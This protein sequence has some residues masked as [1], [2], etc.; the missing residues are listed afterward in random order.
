MLKHEKEAPHFNETM[1]VLHSEIT[2]F[3]RTFFFV[4]LGAIVIIPSYSIILYGVLISLILFVIRIISVKTCTI[5]S[6]LKDDEGIMWW[7]VPRGLAP[8]V[9]SI[10]VLSFAD[11]F[12]EKISRQNALITSELVFIVIIATIVICTVGTYIYL[13]KSQ[14]QQYVKR[15]TGK[16]G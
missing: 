8:A 13:R 15:E 14:H 16:G 3:I 12:P 4:F 2:F 6:P 1:K 5:K 10:L 7:M 9:L 11:Q